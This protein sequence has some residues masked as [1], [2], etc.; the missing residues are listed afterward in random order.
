MEQQ[1][2]CVD[3]HRR[4][5]IW[6]ACCARKQMFKVRDFSYYQL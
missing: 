4:G 6:V 2:A 1:L 5:I 3:P